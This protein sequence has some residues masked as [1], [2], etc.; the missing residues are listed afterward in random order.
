L[1]CPRSY[2]EQSCFINSQLEDGK[3]E[4][5]IATSFSL[6]SGEHWAHVLMKPRRLYSS[7]GEILAGDTGGMLHELLAI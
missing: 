3:E 7:I 5:L 1:E 6:S 4:K 2:K